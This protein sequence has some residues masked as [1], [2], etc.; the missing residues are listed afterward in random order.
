MDISVVIPT[1]ERPEALRQTLRALALVDYP[2]ERW[3]VLVVDNGSSAETLAA[4]RRD[5]DAIEVTVHWHQQS[6][7]GPAAARNLGVQHA[8][9]AIVVLIDNDILVPTDFVARHVKNVQQHPG[10]WIVGRIV[11]QTELRATPFGRYRDAL[12]EQFHELFGRGGLTEIASM[13][14]ANVALPAG[15]FRRLGGFDEAFAIASCEDWDL[16]YRARKAGIHVLYD[17]DNVVVH[18]DWAV[19]LRQFCERQRLYSI[20]DVLLYRKYGDE[21]PRAAMIRENGPGGWR[22]VSLSRRVKTLLKRVLATRAGR[23]LLHAACRTVER[24]APDTRWLRRMYDLAVAVAIFQGVRQGFERYG[25][26]VARWPPRGE[27]E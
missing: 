7:R 19:T 1:F 9:G 13:S 17:P 22:D 16:A 21:S 24:V 4:V 14:A 15:D 11:H 8:R 3:E 23:A 5:I 6:R 2:R 20:S 26:D 18:N 27:R 12:W 10:C 25:A